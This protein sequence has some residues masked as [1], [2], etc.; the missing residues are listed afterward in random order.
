MKSWVC[1]EEFEV[2]IWIFV[3]KVKKEKKKLSKVTIS[4]S[5]GVFLQKCNH[6][7][8]SSGCFQQ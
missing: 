8:Y 5:F 7:E 1:S 6:L 4:F 2:I 3:Q